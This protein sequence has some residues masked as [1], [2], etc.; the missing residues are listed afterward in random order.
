MSTFTKHTFALLS[1]FV[2]CLIAYLPAVDNWFIS[3]DFGIFPFLNSLEQ[4]PSYIFVASS[5]LFRVT[6]Y[7][8]FW[9][10]LKL[11]GLTPELFYA[12]GI[13]LH[14]VVAGLVYFLVL[15]ITGRPL[16]AWAGG[17][18]FAAFE[19]H[20]EAVMWISAANETI[21]TLSCVSFLLLWERRIS[22]EGSSNV[23]PAAAVV[24]LTV[25]LFSKEAAVAMAPVAIVALLLH[26][27]RRRQLLE[28]SI[29]I[30]SLTAAFIVLWL[31]QAERNFFLTEGYYSLGFHFLPVYGRALL[32]LLVPAVPFAAALFL[33]RHRGN[34]S[35][36][37]RALLYFAMLLAITIIPYSF[38]TYQNHLPSRHT[39]LPSVGLA[40]IIGIL[41]AETYARLASSHSRHVCAA[42]FAALIVGN[43]GYI[44]LKKDPQFQERA[45]PMRELIEFLNSKQAHDTTLH[46]CGFP[47]EHAWWFEDA[48][49]RF[50]PVSPDKVELSQNC[51]ITEGVYRWDPSTAHYIAGLPVA[52]AR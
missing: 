26:G 21:L 16:A 49:S 24:A 20:Q 12:A 46:V 52:E 5:E 31:M 34:E 33:L 40:G 39:Y 11:V 9:V 6:S 19:R 7:I 18:F 51:P 2:V 29:P 32:R 13:L 25:A 36:W 47:I 43:V 4:D 45:A 14:A 30:V 15:R 8:Y 22:K 50:S 41:F 48:V 44:W 23:A 35:A 10:V 17:V 3:D 42:I 38:L 27:Y 1:I 28:A 37:N